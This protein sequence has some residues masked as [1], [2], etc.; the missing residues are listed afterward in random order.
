MALARGVK[1]GLLHQPPPTR[2]KLGDATACGDD[3]IVRGEPRGSRCWCRR[4]R[5]DRG[6][7]ASRGL[8]TATGELN[9]GIASRSPLQPQSACAECADSSPSDS[10]MVQRGTLQLGFRSL[11]LAPRERL[12]ASHPARG[13]E[14]WKSATQPLNSVGKCGNAE[15]KRAMARS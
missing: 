6:T 10:S 8:S 5:R 12:L 14:E 11:P 1:R 9:D 2:G 3:T 4:L 15:S 13:I 7:P